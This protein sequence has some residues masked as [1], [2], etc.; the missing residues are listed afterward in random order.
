MIPTDAMYPHWVESRAVSVKGCDKTVKISPTSFRTG[1]HTCQPYQSSSYCDTRLYDLQHQNTKHPA[2]WQAALF[3]SIR[4]CIDQL[5]SAKVRRPRQSR[6]CIMSKTKLKHK[7]TRYVT[8][9]HLVSFG[10][11][12]D[13]LPMPSS[14]WPKSLALRLHGYTLKH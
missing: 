10:T 11:C 2:S 9:W 3:G 1:L 7:S 8:S 12:M 13:Q 14:I 6:C 5:P 4:K